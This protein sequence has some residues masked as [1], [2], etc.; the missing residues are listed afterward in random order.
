M[1]IGRRRQKK[2]ICFSG[3]RAS[4]TVDGW[5]GTKTEPERN[6]E[7]AQNQPLHLCYFPKCK[8]KQKCHRRRG[9]V[10]NIVAWQTAKLKLQKETKN[11][12]RESILWNNTKLVCT[13]FMQL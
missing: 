5:K 3:A 2:S 7:M 6:L 1:N 11:N 10:E 12:S 13:L 9:E 4:I 8:R